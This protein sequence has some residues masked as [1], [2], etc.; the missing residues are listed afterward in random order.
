MTRVQMSHTCL[1]SIGRAFTVPMLTLVA[2][3]ACGDG[4]FELPKGREALEAAALRGDSIALELA[5]RQAVADTLAMVANGEL[6][7]T[8][9]TVLAERAM[10]DPVATPVP[11]MPAAGTGEGMT[12]RAQA[13]GD[14]LA[15]AAAAAIATRLETTVERPSGDS[16]RG[17]IVLEGEAPLTRLLLKS[18]MASLPVALSGMATSE[19]QRLE[20]LEVVVRGVRVSPSD[21]AVNSFEVRA[22]DGVPVID[23]I[24]SNDRG[25]WSVRLADGTRR[26]VVRVPLALQ[27]Y[28][29]ARVWIAEGNAALARHGLIT[30][31][32]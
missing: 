22:S 7:P 5:S 29:G 2:L 31:V 15:R 9:L 1:S 8:A 28:A 26:P 10:S 18:P 6:D 20:G 3:T 14:S 32:R 23:G 12:R 11:Q 4:D 25:G 13:R 19:L 27:P 21:L 16:L 30:R 24:L 17:V